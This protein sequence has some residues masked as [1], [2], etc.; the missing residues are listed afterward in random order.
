MEVEAEIQRGRVRNSGGCHSR[1]ERRRQAEESV[2]VK[3]F[4]EVLRQWSVGCPWSRAIGEVEEVYREHTLDRYQEETQA[5]Y[6]G[7]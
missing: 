7:W 4:R 3:Q 6:R 1:A 5:R 2:E